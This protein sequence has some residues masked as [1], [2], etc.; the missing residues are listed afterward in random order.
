MGRVGAGVEMAGRLHSRYADQA[1]FIFALYSNAH[2]LSSSHGPL[3]H[4]LRTKIICVHDL[5]RS[6]IA[7]LATFGV[8]SAPPSGSLL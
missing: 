5:C 2:A 8:F 1:A 6:R 3:G 4:N 7:Q